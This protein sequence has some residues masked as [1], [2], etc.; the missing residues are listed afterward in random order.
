MTV[1]VGSTKVAYQ[2]HKE[3]LV[4]RCPYF[5]ARLRE[6]WGGDSE[7]LTLEDISVEGFD[8]AVDWMYTNELSERLNCKHNWELLLIAYKAADQLV[9]RD[10]Q[11]K[12]VDLELDQLQLGPCNW[13]LARIQ[14]MWKMELAHTPCYQLAL[15]SCIPELV[16]QA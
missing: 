12:L 15:H 2:V 1:L 4:K 9:M 5:A 3:M 7:P 8:V 16:R 11:N 10:L 13:N 6:C 14:L